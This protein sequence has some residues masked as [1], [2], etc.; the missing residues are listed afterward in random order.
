M[1]EVRLGVKGDGLV[2]GVVADHVA[3]SAVDA[4]VLVDQCHHLLRVVQLIVGSDV[5]QSLPY[6]I[7]KKGEGVGEREG[8]KERKREE[9]EREREE[10][11]NQCKCIT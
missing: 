5:R 7:L 6:H 3:L 2:A 4:H 9:R 10:R 8:V 11:E 1:G